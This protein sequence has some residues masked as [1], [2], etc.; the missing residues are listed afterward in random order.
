MKQAQPQIQ[1]Y[2]DQAKKLQGKSLGTSSIC[3]PEE[4]TEVEVVTFI[5]DGEI[6]IYKRKGTG[7]WQKVRPL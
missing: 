7:E 2:Y 5:E 1:H 4:N 3:K 6:H